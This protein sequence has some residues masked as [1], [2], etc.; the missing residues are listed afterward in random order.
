MRE[1]YLSEF[2]EYARLVYQ[3]PRMRGQEDLP[4]GRAVGRGEQLWTVHM[5]AM[6]GL[7]ERGA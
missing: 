3:A 1:F 7:C 5:V 2:L 6:V 4:W